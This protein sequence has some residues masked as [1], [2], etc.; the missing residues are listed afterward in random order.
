LLIDDLTSK[1]I[2]DPAR[3]YV[4]GP[5]RGGLLTFTMACVFSDRIAAVAPMITGMTDH[6]KEDCHP[7]RPM[8]IVLIAGTNDNTQAY[9]GWIFAAGRLMSIAETIEYWRVLAECTGQEGGTFL[10]HL[11]PNDRTRVA[12]I[13]WTGCQKDTEVRFYKVVGGGHQIPSLVGMAN[14]MGEQKFGL[15]NHDIESAEVIWSFVKRFSLP[16]P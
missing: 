14:P 13:N 10:P 2:A 11:N 5:S 4:T 9:D 16:V 6:Q 12:I 8:P 1:K 15:R 7:T 3:I